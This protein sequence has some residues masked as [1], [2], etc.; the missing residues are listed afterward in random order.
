MMIKTWLLLT[1]FMMPGDLP[2]VPPL[3]TQFQ[4]K[5]QCHQA[6]DALWNDSKDLYEKTNFRLVKTYC[7][8]VDL[9]VEKIDGLFHH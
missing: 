4:T 8:E 9:A 7:L 1:V 2:A 3:V 5:T 6:S